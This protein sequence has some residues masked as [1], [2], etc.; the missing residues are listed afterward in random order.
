MM[1]KSRCPTAYLGR[2]GGEPGAHNEPPN[3]G[4]QEFIN[5]FRHSLPARLRVRARP[6]QTR[7]SAAGIPNTLPPQNVPV[8]T[9]NGVLEL[10][11][12]GLCDRLTEKTPSPGILRKTGI[13]NMLQQKGQ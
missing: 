4:Y 5:V 7:S 12:V 3:L 11:R 6:V 2:D 10:G 9:G 13:Y 1:Q 8:N